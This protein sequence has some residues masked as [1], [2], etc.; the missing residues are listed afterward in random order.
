MSSENESTSVST[1]IARPFTGIEGINH[2]VRALYTFKRASTY[3]ELAKPAGISAAYMSMSLSAA[4]QVGLAEL[5]GKAR[6]SYKLTEKGK[7]YA[8]FMTAGKEANCKGILR[9]I[10][11][12]NPWW[13][14]ITN[15]L[16]MNTGKER[17]ILDLVLDIE[18]KSGKK[19]SNRM[20]G[21][22]G[23]ALASIL[24]YGDLVESKGNKIIPT[25]S[26]VGEEG[27][28]KEEREE[29]L[30]SEKPTPRED[31]ISPSGFA[32]YKVP[33]SF[34]LYVRKNSQGI[35]YFERQIKEDSFLTDWLKLI[36]ASI[37]EKE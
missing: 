29:P 12:T 4:R 17:D 15:F 1:R 28:A 33:E 36:K 23:S 11:F 25:V 35:Q 30:D 19:W 20:R 6:G 27:K 37:K 32:E 21:A 34:I 9:E 16:K 14:E 3:K 10:I 31:T 26:A 2:A 5:T 18:A 7:K 22:L 24:S 8:M 13:S